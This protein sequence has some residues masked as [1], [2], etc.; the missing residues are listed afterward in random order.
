MAMKTSIIAK[1]DGVMLNLVQQGMGLAELIDFEGFEVAHRIG[2]GPLPTAVVLSPSLK[3]IRTVSK[4]LFD[5]EALETVIR[6]EE[7]YSLVCR[8]IPVSD[9]VLTLVVLADP[10]MRYRSTINRAVREIKTLLDESK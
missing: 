2:A 7:G 5:L 1:L 10:H 9:T 6:L 8:Y 3:N 4:E